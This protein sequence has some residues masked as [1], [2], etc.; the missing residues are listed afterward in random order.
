MIVILTLSFS[1]LFAAIMIFP[2][3]WVEL[4]KE[5]VGLDEV[6]SI[7]S[8]MLKIN[9]YLI[10]ISQ[11]KYLFGYEFTRVDMDIIDMAEN[12]VFKQCA[13]R[14]FEKKLYEE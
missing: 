8:T 4:R 6:D 1:W 9:I 10:D 7:K 13:L 5:R 11:K 14:Y 2:L 12:G 3:Y